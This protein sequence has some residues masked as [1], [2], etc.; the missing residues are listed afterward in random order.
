MTQQD[1]AV[2]LR[3]A[4]RTVARWEAV[5][6]QDIALY[7]LRKFANE[8]GAHD[9]A[10]IFAAALDEG[11]LDEDA[12]EYEERHGRRAIASIPDPENPPYRH[13]VT[14]EKDAIEQLGNVVRE[15][16]SGKSPEDVSAE[17][18]EPL[19]AVRKLHAS[20]RPAPEGTHRHTVSNWL[21]ALSYLLNTD[22]PEVRA[23][24][25]RTLRNLRDVYY[26]ATQAK[27]QGSED[28]RARE[29][30]DDSTASDMA[31]DAGEIVTRIVA[32][33]D[34]DLR[35]RD[36]TEKPQST[37]PSRKVGSQIE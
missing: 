32:A 10:Q 28:L 16:T 14:I 33:L 4:V 27:Q 12:I 7:K 20:M 8:K 9:L 23:D 1:L 2:A 35:M 22:I 26:K 36:R 5:G 18:G 11:D 31:R 29:W 19:E 13:L 21:T 30:G 15:L 6:P 37:Q 34:E 24:C 17:L 25:I 3:T